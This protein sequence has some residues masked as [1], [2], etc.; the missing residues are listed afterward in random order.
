MEK[1]DLLLQV[2]GMMCQKN[3]ATT[4]QNTIVGLP[5]VKE[6]VVS[7]EKGTALVLL[8]DHHDVDARAREI[9]QNI[10]DVGYDAV[11][12]ENHVSH[13]NM[14]GKSL[15][16]SSGD[17]DSPV[18]FSHPDIS[19]FVENMITSSDI[20]RIDDILSKTDGVFNL[21]INSTTKAISIWGFA[22]ENEIVKLLI[23]KGFQAV[24]YE[25]YKKQLKDEQLSKVPNI[26]SQNL[27][28]MKTIVLNFKSMKNSSDWKKIDWLKESLHQLA[29]QFQNKNSTFSTPPSSSKMNSP[30]KSAAEKP[31]LDLHYDKLSKELRI[32]YNSQLI[33]EESLKKIVEEHGMTTYLDT[34]GSSAASGSTLSK[35]RE[36]FYNIRGMSC[37]ACAIKIEREMKK[38]PGVVDS[39]VSVMTQQGK[40]IIDETVSNAVGPRDIMNRIN[41]IGYET[42]LLTGSEGGSSSSKDNSASKTMENYEKELS[43]WKR[44]LIISIIFGIPILFF[45]FCPHFWMWLMMIMDEPSGICQKSIPRGQLIMFLLNIPML[46]IVGWKYYKNA[47]MGLLHGIYGM[48]FLVMTGTSIT[49]S[50]SLVELCFACS[51]HHQTHHVFFETTG[52]LLFFVTIGKYIESYAKGKSASSIAELLK[53]QPRE[54]SF[55]FPFCVIYCVS[56]LSIFHIFYFSCY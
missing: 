41:A 34:T 19:I 42:S 36:F 51:S 37:G 43:E 29:F 17:L 22:D 33:A 32:T 11:V 24:N 28:V 9:L 26:S 12:K 15:K 52:M 45:H 46:V 47:F 21:K 49:F 8:L 18:D 27:S 54:V 16:S 35:K 40:A 14:K 3:C 44:L 53:L 31:P 39:S 25:R 30:F 23:L 50:Y 6:A 38:L 10:E 7:F 56:S 5:F 55:V 4:V 1:Y 48:D 2:E 13:L 20:K